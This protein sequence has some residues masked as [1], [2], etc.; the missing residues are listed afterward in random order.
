MKALS[1][2]FIRFAA[3]GLVGTA[4][5]FLTLW[6]G[7]EFWGWAAAMASALGYVLGA[8]TNYALNYK[9]TF[10][11]NAPHAPTV[12]KFFAVVSIG[13]CLNTGL[14]VFLAHVL[15]WQYFAAQIL[16]TAL[17]LIWNFA[18][19]RLWAFRERQHER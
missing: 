16:T 7:V 13:W 1:H 10:K 14:M 2:Q 4:V 5:Q 3:V 17:G 8:L 15:G 12:I 9:Y 19:S 6:L 11:S 18:G